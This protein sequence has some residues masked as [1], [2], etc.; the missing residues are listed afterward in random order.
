MKK[1]RKKATFLLAMVL[2]L[3]TLLA[4]CGGGGG[5][6]AA[7]ENTS[8]AGAA[9]N[10]ASNTAA[11]ADGSPDLSQEVKL[12]MLLIGG[13]PTD[14]DEVF[15]KL[16]ELLKEKINATVEAE[17]LDWADWT[18]KY[19]LKF[20]ADEDFDIAYT[21]NWAFYNAWVRSRATSAKFAA[22]SRR[23]RSRLPI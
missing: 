23:W 17:F 21:A 9:N 7:S 1:M 16:N 5:N 12:K 14:Y 10:T 4:A 13:K 2:A 19:P 11:T 18:Q 20:A 6:K 8:G 15:G 22:T 3:T